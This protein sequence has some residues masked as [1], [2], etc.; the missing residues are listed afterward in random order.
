MSTS[1]L[2]TLTYKRTFLDGGLAGITVD[3]RLPRID[4]ERA[5][6]IVARGDRESTDYTGNRVR[7]T[8]HEIEA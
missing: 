8:N 7:D 3:M 1:T 6:A 2:T 4:R 5:E